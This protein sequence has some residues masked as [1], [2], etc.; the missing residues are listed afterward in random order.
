MF[1]TK[2]TGRQTEEKEQKKHTGNTSEFS[3]AMIEALVTSENRFMEKHALDNWV[4][5]CP[6]HSPKIKLSLL[7]QILIK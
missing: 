1:L 2:Q 5:T 4:N 7:E 3:D 6:I